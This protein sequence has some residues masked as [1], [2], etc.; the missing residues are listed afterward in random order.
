MVFSN[1][2]LRT[3]AKLFIS[4]VARFIWTVLTLMLKWV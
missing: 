4:M 1:P 2:L 3:F